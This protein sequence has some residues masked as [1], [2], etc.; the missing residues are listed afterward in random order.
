MS[1]AIRIQ[2]MPA[3]LTGIIAQQAAL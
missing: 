2:V 1:R 3:I